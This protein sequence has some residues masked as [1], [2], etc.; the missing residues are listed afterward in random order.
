MSKSSPVAPKADKKSQVPALANFQFNN[1]KNP[2]FKKRSL[3]ERD[4][5][6]GAA[7]SIA[8]STPDPENGPGPAE[9]DYS[10]LKG[11]EI[12]PFMVPPSGRHYAVQWKEDDQRLV[13]LYQDGVV[14]PSVASNKE[15]VEV[16]DTVYDGEVHLGPLSERLVSSFIKEGVVPDSVDEDEDPLTSTTNKT[17]QRTKTDLAMVEERLKGELIH[18]GLITQEQV[19]TQEEN[20]I[21]RLLAATQ[22]SL[23]QQMEINFSRKQ[24]LLRIAEEYM[25]YQEYNTLLDDINKTVEAAYTKRFKNVAKSKPKKERGKFPSTLLPQARGMSNETIM[26]ILDS[27]KRLIEDVGQPYFPPAKF[28]AP[29]DTIYGQDLEKNLSVK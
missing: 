6:S 2:K 11:D 10:R 7:P 9:G 17:V 24:A 1:L 4:L 8:R 21:T 23:R 5:G 18:V 14:N 15:Y 13:H 28:Q 16:D 12:T 26:Q 22:E 3:G 29:K 19:A 25:A 20:D 27:R